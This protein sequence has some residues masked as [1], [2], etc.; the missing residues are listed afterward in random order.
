MGFGLF[1]D[2]ANHPLTRADYRTG[3]TLAAWIEK[4]MPCVV[5]R[6][7][8]KYTDEL[9]EILLGQGVRADVVR[10]ALTRL[11]DKGIVF[12]Y[13]ITWP[14]QYFVVRAP[15]YHD[16]NNPADREPQQ[17]KGLTKAESMA[18][19]HAG[20]EQYESKFQAAINSG[21]AALAQ[22][23]LEAVLSLLWSLAQGY[24]EVRK[25][26]LRPEMQE[27]KEW[28]EAVDEALDRAETLETHIRRLTRA[29]IRELRDSEGPDLD[30]ATFRL[31]HRLAEEAVE[32]AEEEESE[33]EAE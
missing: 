8:G 2:R 22:H 11:E 17:M 5:G 19:K 24:G 12:E 15:K 7:P 29:E 25:E 13:P 9:G 20:I 21:D 1:D 30:R 26:R 28:N 10:D 27:W 31:S 16:P 33:K 4:D 32:E 18:M 14:M 3:A 6:I 23:I